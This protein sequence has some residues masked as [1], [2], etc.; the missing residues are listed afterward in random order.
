MKVQVKNNIYYISF[1]HENNCGKEDCRS[2]THCSI[3]KEGEEI[4]VGIGTAQLSLKDTYNKEKGRKITLVRALANA[5]FSK[6][7]K[8]AFWE[9]Y[10]TSS[11]T[12][13][14]GN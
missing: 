7:V 5:G 11:P 13:R 10:R 6:E 9:Q 12:P 4:P 3:K 8:T 14:W 1:K 2:Y